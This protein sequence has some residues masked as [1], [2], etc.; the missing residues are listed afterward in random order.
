MPLP[1]P[2]GPHR[3]GVIEA[4]VPAPTD[5][6]C[7][8]VVVYYP[9]IDEPDAPPSTALCGATSSEPEQLRWLD[10]RYAAALG[11]SHLTGTLGAWSAGAL[12]GNLGPAATNYEVV[13]AAVG[14]DAKPP[15]A[16]G[17]PVAVFSHSLTGWRH[18]NSSLCAELASHGAVVIHM[19]HADG[20][21]CL[22]TSSED[23]RVLAEYVDWAREKTEELKQSTDD[24]GAALE[25]WRRAQVDRRVIEIAAALRRS[26]DRRQARAQGRRLRAD[27]VERGSNGPEFG[28][29]AAVACCARDARFSHCCI[30]DPW[31]DGVGPHRHPLPDADYQ[32]KFFPALKRLALWS[33][34]ASPLQESCGANW[35]SIMAKAGGVGVRHHEEKAGHFAQTD[36]PVVF[37]QGPLSSMAPPSSPKRTRS[38][39]EAYSKGELQ[40]RP[41]GNGACMHLLPRGLGPL[42]RLLLQ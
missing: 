36:A 24:V 17:W 32:G 23:G 29:A 3:V 20:T 28:G 21:A 11:K 7:V 18:V 16:G 2:T 5:A 14:A 31:L 39:S 40:S 1:D 38:D 9:A 10:A 33:C 4:D 26:G 30:Y 13:R 6:G 12:M 15:P 42:R 22:C 19:E 8:P 25:A 27:G 41:C 35:D 37:E 34:G